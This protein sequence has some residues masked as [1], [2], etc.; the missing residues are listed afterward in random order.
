MLL[1]GNHL[2][3]V[4]LCVT[5]PRRTIAT[6]QV[7]ACPSAGCALLRDGARDTGQA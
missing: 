2:Q 4:L 6:M 3:C 5:L 1:T 7:G